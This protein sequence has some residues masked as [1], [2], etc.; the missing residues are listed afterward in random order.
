[1][2]IG[3]REVPLDVT[4]L[5]TRGYPG[6]SICDVLPCLSLRSMVYNL[7]T[8][9]VKKQVCV[10]ATNA[11]TAIPKPVDNQGVIWQTRLD[12][13]D[14][15]V[16][17]DRGEHRE[18]IEQELLSNGLHLPLAHRSDWGREFGSDESWF[19]A[20]R[21]S[22]GAYCYGFAVEVSRSR[23]LPGHLVLRARRFGANASAAAASA[24]LRAM[25]SYAQSQPRILRMQVETFSRDS[26]VHE[27]VAST[28]RELGFRPSTA[29]SSYKNTVVVDLTP[30][31]EEIFAGF[32]RSARRNVRAPGKKGLNTVAISDLSYVDRIHALMKETMART[33]GSYSPMDWARIIE[34]SNRHPELS[35]VVGTFLPEATGPEALVSFA[36][37]CCHG[38]HVTHTNAGSSRNVKVK[39]PLSYAL[40]WDLI[41]WAK[42]NGAVWFD[43]GGVTQGSLE[44]TDNL[45]GISDFKRF[46]SKEVVTVGDEWVLEP[47]PFRAKLARLVSAAANQTRRVIHR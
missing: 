12:G 9:R 2:F 17:P 43:F 41:S 45:G 31:Q 23:A 24:S 18:L 36:W 5:Q 11:E 29:P 7:P 22:T 6:V 27:A 37:G 38:D 8:F 39:V 47:R 20:L 25:T 14:V 26:Q 46:F 44:D 32:D 35:R 3:L 34:F 15:E 30:D 16:W 13:F 1:M 33:G 42:G 40:A 4:I 19:V 10:N 28:A 21:D